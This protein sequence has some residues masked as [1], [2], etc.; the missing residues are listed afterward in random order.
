MEKSNMFG[1][2]KI[3]EKHTAESSFKIQC[4]LKMI[5][6]SVGPIPMAC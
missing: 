2:H 4:P 3:N 5:V 1:T 6:A